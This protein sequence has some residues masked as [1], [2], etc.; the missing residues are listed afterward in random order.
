MNKYD[1]IYPFSAIMTV[2]CFT[3]AS[4]GLCQG[5]QN[6]ASTALMPQAVTQV[7]WK[8]KKRTHKPKTTQQDIVVA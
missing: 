6:N 5:D 1:M 7:E 4:S 3:F 8:K 2:K